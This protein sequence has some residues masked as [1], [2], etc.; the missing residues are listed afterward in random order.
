MRAERK[1]VGAWV[2]GVENVELPRIPPQGELGEREGESSGTSGGGKTTTREREE[3]TAV[4]DLRGLL[5]KA[6]LEVGSSES[7][8][9]ESS[10][11]S[12]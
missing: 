5:E 1:E 2:A 6:L 4:A 3:A 8:P 7:I 12:A 11:F 10:F 9:R